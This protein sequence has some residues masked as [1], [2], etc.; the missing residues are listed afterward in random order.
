[1]KYL[2]TIVVLFFTLTGLANSPAIAQ[3]PLVP[4]PQEL[5]V[6]NNGPDFTNPV[7]IRFHVSDTSGTGLI[8]RQLETELLESGFRTGS[9]QG[10]IAINLGIPD[11]DRSFRNIAESHD[12]LPTDRLGTDG[13]RL[14][15]DPAGIY[16]SASHLKGLFYGAQTLR[17][18]IR[19]AAGTG[20]FP[21]TDIIDWPDMKYRGIMDDISR[22]PIPT[23]EYFRQQIERFSEMK[24]NIM[25][26]YVE[27]VVQIES[28]PDFA[29][30]GGALSLDEWRELADYALK[31]HIIL[32]GSFQ[33]FGHFYPILNLPQYEYL[34]EGNSL[35]SPVLDESYEFLEDVYR[36]MIPVFHSEIFHINADE[37]FDL[38]KGRTKELVDSLG[39][40]GVY[41]RHV[42]RL[43]D[44]VTGKHGKKTAIWGDIVLQEPEVFDMLPPDI[45][46]MTW[47]Y[48]DLESFD[49]YIE[50]IVSR[51][52]DSWI[53]PGVLHSYSTMPDFRTSKKNISKFIRDALK[54]EVPGVLTSAWDDGGSAKFSRMWYGISYAADQSWK[55]NPDD[56]TWDERFSNAVYGDET[57]NLT[58]AIHTLVS[59]ADIP[60]TERMGERVMW[61]KLIPERLE[62]VRLNVNEWD[63]VASTADSALA[64]L[65]ESSPGRY[66]DDLEYLRFT[67][68][69]NLYM[70][71]T[72]FNLL[73]A[74]RLYRD[75]SFTQV[76]NRGEARGYLT[77][78]LELIGESH[79]DL[80]QLRQNYS[81]LWLLENRAYALDR[82]TDLYDFQLREI[83]DLHRRLKQQIDNFDAGLYLMAPNQIRLSVIETD[84]WYF[85]E[86]MMSGPIAL[87]EDEGFEK[88]FLTVM[89]GE[90]DARPGITQEFDIDGRGIRWHRH[91]SDNFTTVE[92]QE[93]YDSEGRRVIYAHAMIDSPDDRTERVLLGSSDGIQVFVNG[94]EV[95][96][97][98]DKRSLTL[99]E[100]E[101]EISLHSGRNHLMLK[102]AQVENDWAFSIRLP[103]ATIQNSKN[104]YRIVP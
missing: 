30:P 65:S 60:A 4:Y 16:I 13:Y 45:I 52:F 54:Y 19:H 67:A 5:S 97:S 21:G 63:E 12:I 103:D 87:R 44:I 49:S 48:S 88:D 17:Q 53:V 64:M 89:G 104:R 72:R 79:T 78:A 1:M 68:R 74:A 82:T 15:S 81:N 70:A 29:A 101:F 42:N 25:T 93:R 92:L 36:E 18:L 34:G 2:L 24:I 31:H 41:A 56:D 7:Y 51:G 3:L 32:I 20:S 47:T 84:G 58:G 85:R 61:T 95:H 86:W 38:G 39:T 35:L 77:R 6:S 10:S 75:A 100:D 98:L 57:G 40:G 102:I 50:P 8:R 27:N 80:K 33:S 99:D 22:G 73:N 43:Y 94:T 69:Q 11:Q 83:S 9:G 62:T 96:R 59:L 26:H 76:E 90:A 71:N 55:N 46:I 28:R 91:E 23:M 14:L 37:T 66:S